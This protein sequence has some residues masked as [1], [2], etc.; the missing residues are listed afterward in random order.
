MEHYEKSYDAARR[1]RW[2]RARRTAQQLGAAGWI[3][4]AC[5]LGIAAVVTWFQM[6]QNPARGAVDRAAVVVKPT[7]APVV[8]VK[9][10]PE[11]APPVPDRVTGDGM[12]IVGKQMK[13]GVYQS[14]AGVSCYWERLAG[15]SG[16]HT[17][18]L[19]NGGYR[20]GRQLVEVLASDF[21]F[22]SQ[23]C[24]EWVMVR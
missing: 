9:P 2:G 3:S 14:D 17:D 1:T 11:Y 23:G 19:D 5:V 6:Q 24:G 21:A 7:A 20:R 22:T 18:L 4:A 13:P 10:R 15:L 16:K 12:W 8:P